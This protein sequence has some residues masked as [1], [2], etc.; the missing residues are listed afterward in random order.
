MMKIKY[1]EPEI[2]FGLL[3]IQ[4]SMYVW[5]YNTSSVQIASIWYFFIWITTLY[6]L[7]NELVLRT[8]NQQKRIARLNLYNPNL[9]EENLRRREIYR[10][11]VR[12]PV[13]LGMIGFILLGFGSA[14]QQKMPDGIYE[15]FVMLIV[16]FITLFGSVA[17][18]IADIAEKKDRSWVSF[19][20]LS[21]L[22]S[23]LI[24]WLIVAV[25]NNDV[26]NDIQTSTIAVQIAELNSLFQSGAID[27]DEYKKAKAKLLDN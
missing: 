4:L 15:V 20:W 22:I 23:P 16:Y 27:E 14:L 10:S 26:R 19:F 18:K 11:V 13:R 7:I 6:L 17:I 1:S 2:A 12:F 8:R 21:I 24:T 5:L 25:L 9:T 3:P